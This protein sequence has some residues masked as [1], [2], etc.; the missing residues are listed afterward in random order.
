V[1]E[2]RDFG[3][4]GL[5]YRSALRKGGAAFLFVNMSVVLQ[6]TER[7]CSIG[8]LQM[9][10]ACHFLFKSTQLVRAVDIL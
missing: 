2:G 5:G 6:L 7:C 9:P 8:Y 1:A 3:F 10:S 4:E